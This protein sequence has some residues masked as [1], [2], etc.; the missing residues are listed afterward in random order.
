MFSQHSLPVTQTRESKHIIW[1]QT[2]PFPPMPL[3]Q[4]SKKITPPHLSHKPQMEI[5]PKRNFWPN[6]LPTIPVRDLTIQRRENDLVLA[7]F[8][9]S[10][11]ILDDYSPIRNFTEDS[12]NQEAVLFEPRKALQYTPEIGG[13]SSDGSASFKTENPKY[14]TIISYYIKEGYKT[15]DQK[16]IEKEN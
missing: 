14:G 13:T 4:K 1:I 7:T 5:I 8:G 11:Y 16:R 10:F 12:L 9:R 2:L 3:V 15:L 6:G